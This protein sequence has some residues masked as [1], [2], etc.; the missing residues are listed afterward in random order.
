M[1]LNISVVAHVFGLFYR[2]WLLL[3]WNV[4]IASMSTTR[5]PTFQSTLGKRLQNHGRRLSTCCMNCWVGLYVALFNALNEIFRLFG[6]WI[7]CLNLECF[8]YFMKRLWS[9]VIEPTVPC[10][11]ITWTG[12]S[13]S[14]IVWRHL[15]VNKPGPF[16]VTMLAC[17]NSPIVTKFHLV[18]ES[19]RCCIVFWLRA[20]RCWTSS[21][22]ITSSPSFPCWIN[23]DAT[24]RSE[25]SNIRKIIS[26]IL[27]KIYVNKQNLLDFF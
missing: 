25:P 27:K 10:S 9:E 19:W 2:V 3:C 8:S 1:S 13:V 5:Q 22:R 16:H 7:W 24:T 20:L 6:L 15:Q 11:A 14:W 12:W 17:A 23:M 26:A 18:Q 4:W 21:R